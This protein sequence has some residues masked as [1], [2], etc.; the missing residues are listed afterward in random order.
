MNSLQ[1]F[2]AREW[3]KSGLEIAGGMDV[4]WGMEWPVRMA[5]PGGWC[6]PRAERTAGHWAGTLPASRRHLCQFF[7]CQHC[8]T[9]SG[10]VPRIFPSLSISSALEK[11]EMCPL[12]S[13][14]R[15]ESKN[16]LPPRGEWEEWTFGC[17]PVSHAAV[18]WPTQGGQGER[19]PVGQLAGRALSIVLR[20]KHNFAH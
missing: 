17:P 16:G 7:S 12:K 11:K 19:M 14:R 2:G 20:A 5:K 9:L 15:D 1:Y 10:M 13:A 18:R 8:A 6:W 4:L 3:T